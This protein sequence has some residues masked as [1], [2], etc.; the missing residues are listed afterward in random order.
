MTL[1]IERVTERDG[2]AL[3]RL[4]GGENSLSRFMGS[5]DGHRSSRA[6]REIE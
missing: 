2:M 3:G 4:T 1:I 5:G 6:R